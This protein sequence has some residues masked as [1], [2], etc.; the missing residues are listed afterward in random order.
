MI[1]RRDG[2]IQRLREEVHRLQRLLQEVQERTAN[3]V[4]LLQQQLTNKSQDVEVR[5]VHFMI[6]IRRKE[7]SLL[8]LTS[9]TL[10]FS[11]VC[12][13]QACYSSNSV[14]VFAVTCVCFVSKIL[15]ARLQ[16]QHDYVKIKAEL[17]SHKTSSK[18]NCKNCSGNIP[19]SLLICVLS[20]TCSSLQPLKKN[21]DKPVRERLF[22]F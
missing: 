21:A 20:L 8:S 19:S 9:P 17:R 18:K 14:S 4:T 2:E 6:I 13:D 7:N 3:H 12:F 1:A 22:N 11:E 16:S 10:F 5:T 15:Q